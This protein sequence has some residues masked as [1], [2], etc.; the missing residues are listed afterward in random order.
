MISPICL[1]PAL[2]DEKT[3]DANYDEDGD[4]DEDKEEEEYR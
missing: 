2:N 3:A 4:A 1:A